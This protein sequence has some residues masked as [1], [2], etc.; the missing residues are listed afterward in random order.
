MRLFAPLACTAVI[1]D[2]PLFPP[3][4]HTAAFQRTGLCEWPAQNGQVGIYFS[5]LWCQHARFKFSRFK[6]SA[7]KLRRIR[8]TGCVKKVSCCTVIDISKARNSP[9]V[10]FYERSRTWKLATLLVILFMWWNV[11]FYTLLWR[12]LIHVCLAV[13]SLT[14]FSHRIFKHE[15]I[16]T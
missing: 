1:M 2:S 11:L 16:V 14:A 12:K 15:T 7:Y 10:K 8:P 6:T 13:I 4:S 9:N 3:L 5:F